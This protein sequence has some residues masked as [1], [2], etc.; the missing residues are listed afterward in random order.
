MKKT[1]LSRREKTLIAAAKK[2]AV[3]A[4][5][6]NTEIQVIR[7]GMPFRRLTLAA[8]RNVNAIE[9]RGFTLDIIL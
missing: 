7:N 3:E 5:E 9:G 1:P 6:Y 8:L 4:Y 2:A